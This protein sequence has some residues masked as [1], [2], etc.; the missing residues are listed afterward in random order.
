MVIDQEKKSK[1]FGAI[2][3]NH[4]PY[5]MRSRLKSQISFSDIGW[6][7]ASFVWIAPPMRLVMSL[8]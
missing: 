8:N 1:S 5:G 3:I 6:M 2:A 4:T 7:G